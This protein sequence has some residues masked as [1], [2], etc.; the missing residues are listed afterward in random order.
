MTFTFEELTQHQVE[1]ALDK[2]ILEAWNLLQEADITED[3]KR[4]IAIDT[5]GFYFKIEDTSLDEYT[6]T[7]EHIDATSPCYV[8]VY[9]AI[10]Y[11]LI[12]IKTS[13]FGVLAPD[14]IDRTRGKDEFPSYLKK[15]VELIFELV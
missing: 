14:K 3:T 5:L 11:L 13:T 10:E 8:S 15:A 9:K 6:I 4:A 1:Y 2:S 7:I 12:K